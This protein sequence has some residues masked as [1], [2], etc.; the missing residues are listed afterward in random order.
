MSHTTMA[1][2]IRICVISYAD[3]DSETWK[4]GNMETGKSRCIYNVFNGLDLHVL[5]MKTQ[6]SKVR[7]SLNILL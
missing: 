1:Q 6:M 3:I 4:H 7:Y 5:L 2:K